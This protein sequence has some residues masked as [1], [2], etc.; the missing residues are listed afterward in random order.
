VKM[1]REFAGSWGWRLAWS[2]SILFVLVILAATI[3]CGRESP[4]E[5]VEARCVDCH[6][7]SIVEA[8]RKTSQEWEATVSRMVALGADLNDRQ[9]EEVVEYLSSTYG[10]EAP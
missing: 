6:A 4:Q 9:A 10:V 5:L 3:G 2:L 1:V 8:S 7:L